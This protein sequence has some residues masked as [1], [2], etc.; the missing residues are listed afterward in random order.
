MKEMFASRLYG[1]F[2]LGLIYLV[3]ATPVARNG[4]EASMSAH[5]LIQMP[6]LVMIGVGA[7]WLLSQRWQSWLLAGFGG[8]VPLTTLAL[9]AMSYWML[10]RAMDAALAEPAMETAKFISLPLLVGLPLVLAWGKLSLIGRG[11]VLTNLMTMLAVLGWLYIVAPVRVC[12]SYL[13]DAQSSAG[14]WMVRLSVLLFLCWLGSW[15]I[16]NHTPEQ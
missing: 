9:V 2:G 7:G 12:N 4:L 14:W 5:F 11:F 8:A 1:S 16:G 10:P 15:F 3:L 13:V 6:L